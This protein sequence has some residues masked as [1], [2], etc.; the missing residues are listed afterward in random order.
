MRVDGPLRSALVAG[1]LLA[2]PTA[3]AKPP[4]LTALFPAGARR[5]ETVTVTASGTFDHWPVPSWADSP[6]LTIEAV[7]E[8]K[9][10]LSIRVTDDADPGVHWLRLYD[11]EGATVLRPFL[12]GTLPE[13]VEAEP[14]D[15]PKTPQEVE[16]PAVTINGRLAKPGDVDGF[17][18]ALARGQTLV[19]D[20]E[21][22]RH[23]GSPMDAVLQVAS[24]SGFV[25]AQNDDTTGRDPR[26]VFEAP[27]DATYLVRL[28]AFPAA[29]DSGIRFAGGDAFIYRLTLTTGGF[30]DHAFPLAVSADGPDPVSAV[31]TN[32]PEAARLLIVPPQAGGE[33]SRTVSHPRLAGTAEVCLVPGPT[34]VEAEPD[35]PAHAQDIPDRIILSGRIDPPGDRDAFRLTLRKGDR[36]LI[37]VASRAL[38]LP[39]DPVLRILDAEGKTL[40]ESDDTGARPDPELAFTAPADGAYRVIVRDLNDRGGPRFAYLLQVLVPEPDFVLA[41][42]A[43]QFTL[44]PGKPTD[45]VVTIDRRD[46]FSEPIEVVA[47]GL[48]EG[49]TAHPATS[50][51]GDASAK[52]VT[53]KLAA[54][55][56]PHSGQIRIV[57]RATGEPPREHTAR[58]A[59]PGFEARTDRPW[60]TIRGLP[61][62]P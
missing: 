53:L 51:P 41:L 13:I 62:Q 4:T 15:D 35:D 61:I 3:L 36:R 14:N 39:L 28:F 9:G 27:A 49:V 33:E 59:I 60:L 2:G 44:T 25:L 21:A 40:S 42:A 38:G 30:L 48:P 58:A 10:T 47:E 26:I 31:G 46:G 17:A 20:V 5:G 7:T 12:V 54:E 8:K 24:G 45:I 34:A 57:G 22:N 52:S 1:L 55:S 19:A 32:V 16:G 6:G 37:R 56:G 23:L 18:I 11:E 43:D 29:P 50:N